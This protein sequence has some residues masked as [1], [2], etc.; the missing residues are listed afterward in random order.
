MPHQVNVMVVS[1]QLDGHPLIVEGQ[2]GIQELLKWLVDGSEK[3]AKAD[4][5]QSIL[6]TNLGKAVHCSDLRQPLQPL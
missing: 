5:V 1:Q 3:R 4:T 2:R 6:E